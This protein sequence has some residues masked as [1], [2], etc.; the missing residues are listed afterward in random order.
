M[1]AQERPIQGVSS[2]TSP[3]T[4]E[5]M[6]LSLVA[7]RL[8]EEDD[9]L[10]SFLTSNSFPFHVGRTPSMDEAR[11]RIESGSFADDEQQTFWLVDQELGRVGFIR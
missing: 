4:V 7:L 10:V 3:G 1:L 8:P 2:D 6:N 11:R 9:G 5:G